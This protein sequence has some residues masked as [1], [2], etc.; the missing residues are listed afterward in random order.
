MD[1]AKKKLK[2]KKLDLIILNKISDKRG[3]FESDENKVII[4]SKDEDIEKTKFLS[5]EEIAEKI[6]RFIYE[7]W[8]KKEK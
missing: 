6:L 5:K 7:K 1:E 8:V 2:E 4:I 3:G